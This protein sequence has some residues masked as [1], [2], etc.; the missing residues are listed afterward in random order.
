MSKMG[1]QLALHAAGN[2]LERQRNVKSP[3]AHH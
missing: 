3:M 2:I 1:W